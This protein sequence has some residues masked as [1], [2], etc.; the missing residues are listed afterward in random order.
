[1]TDFQILCEMTKKAQHLV[2]LMKKGIVDFVFTKKSNGAKRKAKGT[3]KRDLI[4]PEFQ[5]KRGRPKKRPEGLVIYYDV[6]KNDIRSFRDELLIKIM[7]SKDNG[8]PDVQEKPAKQSK[9]KAPEDDAENS[10]R[11]Q[12]KQDDAQSSDDAEVNN[13]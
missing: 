1:M 13:K 4:P 2:D 6:D 5:R 9:D 8:K 12:K 10:S 11:K 7:A 3:L